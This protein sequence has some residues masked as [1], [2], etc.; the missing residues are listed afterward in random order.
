V[1][2]RYRIFAILAVLLLVALG[3]YGLST[4]HATD[5]VLL[6]T[7]DANQVIVS[8]QITGRI[9]KLTVTEGQDVKAGDLIAVLEQDELAAAKS[10][11]D[12]QAQ[13]TRTQIGMLKATA[14]STTG[15]TTSS[16]ANA[17][18]TFSAAAASLAE[19]AANRQNQES[20]TRRTV[21]LASQGILSAQ[22]QDTAV[23]ALKAAQAHEQAAHEQM[24]AAE[25][26]LKAA[27]ARTYQAKA[28]WENVKSTQGLWASAQAQ[29][30]EAQARLGYTTIKAPIS[31]KVGI[32]AA[33][34]G[35]VVNPGTAIVTIVELQ[36]TWVYA[37]LPETEADSVKLGDTLKVRMPGGVV[38]DGRVIVKSAEGDF[39]T[40]RDVSRLKRDIKTIRLKLLI[41]NPGE[42]FVPGMTAEVLL[43][44][45][46]LV[47]P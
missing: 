44:K 28:A 32:W 26:A 23:Q 46:R 16:V 12:A 45:S 1:N 40:Q 14:D 39:A 5:L 2:P 18:A 47:H 42:R 29:A 25:A 33:R 19:S 11:S 36:Q 21:A 3:Y 9:Q 13:S 38:V 10:A 20:L 6:G 37:P 24:A 31:G 43:P 22:D 15:D 4:D 27:Q 34:E 17:Q 7:V 35:E 41:D 8:A 30:V